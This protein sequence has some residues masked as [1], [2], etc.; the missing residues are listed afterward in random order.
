M[1]RIL[2]SIRSIPRRTYVYVALF[3][4]QGSQFEGMGKDLYEAH[5][6]T[7]ALFHRADQILKLPLSKVMFTG[8]VEQLIPTELCQPAVFLHA[9]GLFQAFKDLNPHVSLDTVMGHSLGELTGLAARGILSF[10]DALIL[11]VSLTNLK[12]Y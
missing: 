4:G 2:G 7:Q 11:T 12:R 9:Y 10:T 1:S 5:P 3:P 8:T 6:G